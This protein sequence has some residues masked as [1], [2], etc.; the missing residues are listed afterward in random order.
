MQILLTGSATRSP[1]SVA[2]YGVRAPKNVDHTATAL[3]DLSDYCR[4][5]FLESSDLGHAW[6]M[7]LTPS[8]QPKTLEQ[9]EKTTTDDASLRQQEDLFL[10]QVVS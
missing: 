8:L 2:A 3:K 6:N 1:S 9:L 10:E 5:Y 4:L 7:F